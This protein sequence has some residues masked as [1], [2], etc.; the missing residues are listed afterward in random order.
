MNAIALQILAYLAE[1]PDASDTAE[2]IADWWLPA[3]AA[4]PRRA[5]LERALS[6]LTAEGW[7]SASRG[8]DATVRY[9]M[10]P[11]QEAAIA[12]LRREDGS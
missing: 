12:A 3:G 7:L 1:N 4:R 10:A 6:D 2:G 5:V 9:R 11:H 8:I